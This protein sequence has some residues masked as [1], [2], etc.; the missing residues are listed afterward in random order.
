MHRELLPIPDLGGRR[1]SLEDTRFYEADMSQSVEVVQIL[2]NEAID[3]VTRFG[4]VGD[5]MSKPVNYDEN[6][7]SK[8]SP[9]S[10]PCT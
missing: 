4:H 7:V 3:I 8:P 10:S 2:K 9:A 6:N 5:S 1:R